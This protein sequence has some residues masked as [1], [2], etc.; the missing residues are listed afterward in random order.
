MNHFAMGVAKKLPKTP[1]RP[2]SPKGTVN[3]ESSDYK[4]D[5]SGKCEC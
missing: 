2:S 5:D 4:K 3:P 1:P